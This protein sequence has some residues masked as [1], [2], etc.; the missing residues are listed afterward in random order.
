MLLTVNEVYKDFSQEGSFFLASKKPVLKGVSLQ[1]ARGE[2]LG[3][4]G[5]SGS[6]KSTLG[7]MMIGIEPPDRGEV[8]FDGQNIYKSA[9]WG[10]RADWRQKISAVF[11]DY[12]S[13]VNPRF[14]VWQIIGEPMH[15]RRRAAS[16]GTMERITYLLEKVGLHGGYVNRYPHELSGGQLQRVCIARAIATNPAFI[17]LDEPVS[18]LDVS[19]QVQV[20][21][22]LAS[23]KE[24][25]NLSYLFISHDLAAV[26]YLC[27]RA[28]FFAEGEIVEEVPRI[29]ELGRVKAAYSRKLLHSVL[30]FSEGA[31][32]CRCRLAGVTE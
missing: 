25:F 12:T 28:L 20:M 3:L 6:G 29:M 18:S 2:C 30:D 9:G 11:Q 4:I 24:E 19:V 7:R 26:A 1:L 13:S 5:E 10:K 21:D 22:L 17:L 27:D 14:Q 15:T 23:L 31:A 16:A 8:L 32:D